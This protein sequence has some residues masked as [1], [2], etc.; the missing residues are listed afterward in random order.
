MMMMMMTM[1][2]LQPTAN[3]PSWNFLCKHFSNFIPIAR[4]I[5]DFP[6]RLQL[7][8]Q[9]DMRTTCRA[10]MKCRGP[11]TPQFRYDISM[12]DSRA[13]PLDGNL[14]HAWSLLLCNPLDFHSIG[15][16]EC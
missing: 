5:M 2:L 12:R 16:L 1:G 8:L 3:R 15:R 4:Y 6:V 13:C 7:F 10:M 9:S 11:S 14:W